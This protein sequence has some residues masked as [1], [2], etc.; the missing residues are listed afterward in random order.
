MRITCINVLYTL[1]YLRPELT[2]V[3]AIDKFL[4]VA[5]EVNAKKAKEKQIEYTYIRTML[6]FVPNRNDLQVGHLHRAS[7]GQRTQ[8]D[9]DR[10][11]EVTPTHF[12]GPSKETG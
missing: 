7:H 8:N 3:A 11:N 4:R 12:D 5:K 2:L 10:P 6:A 1:S 9:E